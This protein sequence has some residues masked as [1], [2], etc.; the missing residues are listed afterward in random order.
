MEMED[1][2]SS[3]FP[4]FSALLPNPG[5]E[6][7]GSVEEH[8]VS[9][10]MGVTDNTADGISR[11][12]PHISGGIGQ[13]TN[14]DGSTRTGAHVEG[15]IYK[16][17]RDTGYEIGGLDVGVN[18]GVGTGGAGIF[19]DTKHDENGRIIEQTNSVGATAN[20]IEGGINLANEDG[21]M[22]LGLSHGG[23]A[24]GREHLADT[25][26]DGD[27]ETV[28]GGFDIGPV[29]FDIKSKMLGGI[30]NH[31]MEGEFGDAVSDLGNIEGMPDLDDLTEIAK[32]Q[33]PDIGLPDLPSLSDLNP[34]ASDEP[35]LPTGLLPI[36]EELP[37]GRMDTPGY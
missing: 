14:P 8:G 18:M 25:D 1:I 35:E 11:Q 17:S 23:G 29:S 32:P 2:V 4:Y 12:G 16:Q 15:G 7:H 20:V 24:G 13:Y 28:G 34:F 36:E 10:G 26:G 6:M 9:G 5:V 31:V 22:K 19:S 3:A 33:M 21:G 27:L 30:A 37:T